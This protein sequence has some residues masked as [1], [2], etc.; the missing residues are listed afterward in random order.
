ML[1]FLFKLRLGFHHCVA[2]AVV[3]FRFVLRAIVRDALD[4]YFGVGAAG[5]S[6][7]GV[8][9]VVSGLALVTTGN[10]PI[11]FFAFG[12]MA[13]RFGQ[14][15]MD[16]EISERVDGIGFLASLDD[17]LLGNLPVCESG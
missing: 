7:I 6:A 9:P 8:G 11:E 3:R 16:R 17:E 14:V 2:R 12:Q 10:F 5:E 13:W 15:F 1:S 4:D